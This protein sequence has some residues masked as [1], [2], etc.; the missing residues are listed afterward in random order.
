[1]SS[2]KLD[3]GSIVPRQGLGMRF[4]KGASKEASYQ[5]PRVVPVPSWS[6]PGPARR[7]CR[8]TNRAGSGLELEGGDRS[9]RSRV[10]DSW[11]PRG[12]INLWSSL[13]CAPGTD[14]VSDFQAGRAT[15]HTVRRMEWPAQLSGL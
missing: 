9:R 15:P 5:E 12:N 11:C 10:A 14:R 1:M 8:A 4:H 6:L 7:V 13:R 2:A 3:L